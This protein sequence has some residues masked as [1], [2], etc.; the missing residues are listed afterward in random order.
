MRAGR[1][2]KS[3]RGLRACGPY[4]VMELLLPG[5]TLLAFLLWLS[6]RSGLVAFGDMHRY[7]QRSQQRPVAAAKPHL[8]AAREPLSALAAWSPDA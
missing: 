3:L 1:I 6:Q 7:L 5:G 8:L 2:G 4:L